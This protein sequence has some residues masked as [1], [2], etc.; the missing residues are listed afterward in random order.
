MTTPLLAE[1]DTP[2]AL[3]SAWRR[4]RSEGHRA[5]DAFTPFPLEELA[6]AFDPA[7]R[8]IRP[9]MA[10]AGFGAAAA[11]YAL[12]WWSAVR[13][14]PLN[15]GGRPLHSW[16]V[17]VLV[18][19]EVG[20]LAAAVAGF[21]AFLVTCGLPRLHHPLFVMPQFERASQDRFLLLVAP[22]GDPAA[23][24]RLLEEAGAALV[25]ETHP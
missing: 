24:R 3:V 19:F 9:A 18:P 14:Y 7:P 11:M 1:F 15:S 6:E 5:I 25:A 23:L 2:D 4:A 12:Q 10:S 22:T 13:D 8:W 20:V 16:Q 21:V 17:F